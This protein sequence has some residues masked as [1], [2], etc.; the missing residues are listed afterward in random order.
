MGKQINY[1]MDYESFLKVAQAALDEGC[2]IIRDESKPEPPKPSNDLSVITEKWMRYGFYLPELADLEY[3]IDSS[4]N[5]HVNKSFNQLS[6]AVIEASF[7]KK[8][9]GKGDGTPFVSTARL[10]IPTGN[11]IKDGEWNARSERITKIYN[12]LARLVKKM[13]P[14][15][16]L[17]VDDIDYN[18]EENVVQIKRPY[19]AYISPAC[20]EW[21][22]QGYELYPLL[23][24]QKRYQQYM[25]EHR[26]K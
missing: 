24:S 12:K 4:G 22:N 14:S 7:S 21:R 9:I 6:L 11:Y 16:S 25:E 5:F 15:I 26:D 18:E 10:Y 2:L 1:Y 19:K 3:G 17:E 20:M 13:A 8:L 23:A